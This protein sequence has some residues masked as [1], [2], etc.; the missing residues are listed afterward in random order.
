MSIGA[1]KLLYNSHVRHSFASQAMALGESLPMIGKL[2]DHWPVTRSE[3]RDSDAPRHCRDA[4]TYCPL[5]KH[6]QKTASHG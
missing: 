5:H 3:K 1:G 4:H 2:L 6:R